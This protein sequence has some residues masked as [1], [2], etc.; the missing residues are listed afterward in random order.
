LPDPDAKRGHRRAEFVN[1]GLRFAVLN[2][3]SPLV[4]D[5]GGKLQEQIAADE[6]AAGRALTRQAVGQQIDEVLDALRPG[7]IG[8]ASLAPLLRLLGAANVKRAAP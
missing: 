6:T 4:L 3:G 5:C 1:S 7:T 2:A 8:D